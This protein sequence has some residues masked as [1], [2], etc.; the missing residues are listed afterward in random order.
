MSKEL[1]EYLNGNTDGR[2]RKLIDTL[3][4]TPSIAWYPSSGEDFRALL[5]LSPEY[6]KQH[7]AGQAETFPDIFLYTDH[8]P[9][10]GS[11]FLSTPVVHEDK[12]TKIS[13]QYMEELPRI[14]VP[15]D[16]EIVHFPDKSPG[17][18]KVFFLELLVESNQLGT[19]TYPV[20][21]C[22]VENEA[23]CAKVLLRKNGIISH[24]IHVRYGGGCGG[25]GNASGIW[26]PNVLT[27]LGCKVIVT[28]SHY[29]LQNGDEAAYRLYP[30]L[31]GTH[32][33]MRVIRTV[34]SDGW[35]GHGDVSW[36]I[37]DGDDGKN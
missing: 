19:Y 29:Y 11:K 10:T 16:R 8:C 33:V 6:A 28:D 2:L 30:E 31:R 35:S 14:T 13:V 26:V 3:P 1:L 5:Y 9:W 32:P 37:V 15:V 21:F 24:A 20:I 17:L 22:F 12:R 36:N 23:F 27:R 34:K 4:A 7:P 18:G 25:G